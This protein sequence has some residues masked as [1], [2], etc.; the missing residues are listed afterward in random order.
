MKVPPPPPNSLKN[1]L[2]SYTSHWCGSIAERLWRTLT[3]Q[4][5]LASIKM[6]HNFLFIKTLIRIFSECLCQHLENISRG[7]QVDWRRSLRSRSCQVN[8]WIIS[9]FSFFLFFKFNQ[10]L[11]SNIFF[12]QKFQSRLNHVERFHW[13]KFGTFSDLWLE[14]SIVPGKILLAD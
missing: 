7:Q 9:K 5:L 10:L 2:T 6:T 13:N 11:F 14:G 3:H 8:N 12:C 1:L 4:T